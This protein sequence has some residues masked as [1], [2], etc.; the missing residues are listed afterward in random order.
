M[1]NGDFY[2]VLGV[3]KT[4]SISEIKEAYRKLALEF[5][6]DRNRSPD[7][8]EKLKEASAAYSVLSDPEKRA[9]YDK[10]GPEKYEDPWEVL[11]YRLGRDAE[12]RETVREYEASRSVQQ[13]DAAGS[14]AILIFFLLL[15]DFEVPS[16]VLGPWYYVI[17]GF[18]I[19]CIVMG[20]YQSFER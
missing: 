9:L 15:L 12:R 4:A 13:Y 14:T 6:P 5:H 20:I 10:L 17:N 8:E 19:L 2:E 16:W 11:F 1:K 7:S 18:I 3:S